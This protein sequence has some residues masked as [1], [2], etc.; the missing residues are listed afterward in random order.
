MASIESS[1][2]VRRNVYKIKQAMN[3]GKR[4]WRKWRWLVEVEGRQANGGVKR[5]ENKLNTYMKLSKDN[6][7]E[8]QNK[9][10]SKCLIARNFH[11]TDVIFIGIDSIVLIYIHIY[12]Y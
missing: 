4:C 5:S 11:E 7:N 3:V 12:I 10:E 9:R 2:L 6:F 1:A 8:Y